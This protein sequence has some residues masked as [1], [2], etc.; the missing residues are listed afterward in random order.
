MANCPTESRPPTERVDGSLGREPGKD[1]QPLG[2]ARVALRVA[3]WTTRGFLCAVIAVVS[4]GF[5]RQVLQWWQQEEPEPGRATLLEGPLA[6]LGEPNRL[7]LVQFGQNPWKFH[8]M[9]MYGDVSSAI[10]RLKTECVRATAECHNIPMP[11]GVEEKQ[12]LES[13]K[14]RSPAAEGP[15][16]AVYAF[17]EGV[18]LVVGIR[19][20]ASLSSVNQAE[21]AK[22]YAALGG[23]PQLLSSS[24][25]G[26]VG[27]PPGEAGENGL[28][29]VSKNTLKEEHKEAKARG[30]P[31]QA[32][33]EVAFHPP[34]VVSWGF[35][36][37]HG[38][39]QWT[40]YILV[41]VSS[42]AA[43]ASGAARIPLPPEATLICSLE[44]LQGG[45]VILFRG[46]PR[47]ETW[48]GFYESYFR[49]E[50]GKQLEP[51]HQEAGRWRAR[52]LWSPS[53]EKGLPE[54]IPQRT[55]ELYFGP[56]PTGSWTGLIWIGA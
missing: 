26:E 29:G 19:K 40:L 41:A 45:G 14:E 6:G 47:P 16:W 50:G 49:A 30:R 52:F 36:I 48:K 15:G 37:P 32:Q 4:V 35:G 9:V 20:P 7:H 27:S 55:V 39:G 25:P 43:G 53:P 34:G 33:T 31:T 8:Q 51:W 28:P 18:P 5:G 17:H 13:L 46:P 3:H 23:D 10:E 56:E 11:R 38:P 22:T 42:G 1:A 24:P 44:V 12:F 54:K 2:F 21:E